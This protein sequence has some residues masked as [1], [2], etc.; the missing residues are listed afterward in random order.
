MATET[1]T[2]QQIREEYKYGFSKRTYAF[3][4]TYLLAAASWAA[5]AAASANSCGKRS[6]AQSPSRARSILNYAT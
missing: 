3:V 1:E 6:P 5:H 4:L 2:V